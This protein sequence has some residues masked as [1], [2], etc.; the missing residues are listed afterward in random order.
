MRNRNA[1]AS[2]YSEVTSIQF[3]GLAAWKVKI[4]MLFLYHLLVLCADR[5]NNKWSKWRLLPAKED[6]PSKCKQTHSTIRHDTITHWQSKHARTHAHITRVKRLI[7]KTPLPPVTKPKEY[8]Y[9]SCIVHLSNIHTH[10]HSPTR[11]YDILTY[12][13]ASLFR[14]NFILFCPLHLPSIFRSLI[15]INIAWASTK[16]VIIFEHAATWC[17]ANWTNQQWTLSLTLLLLLLLFHALSTCQMNNMLWQLQIYPHKM[18]NKL[19]KQVIW[20][21]MTDWLTEWYS[22]LCCALTR[23][24]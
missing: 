13:S 12:S 23:L 24:S 16:K 18:L 22:L 7:I 19:T 5:L 10:I 6:N 2:F 11:V 14:L 3:G 17:D 1:K 4:G 9:I 15:Y 8:V 20:R 21:W